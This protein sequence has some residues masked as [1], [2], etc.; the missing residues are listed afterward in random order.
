KAYP[1]EMSGGMCQRVMIAIALAARPALLIADEPT[2]GLD[3]T[4]QAVIMDIIAELAGEIGMATI[5]IT[6]DLALAGQRADRILVTPARRVVGDAA[7]PA[8]DR[9]SAAPL[10]G[11][12]HPPAAGSPPDPRR[13]PLDP[14]RAPRLAPRRSPAMLLFRT[15]PAQDRPLRAAAAAPAA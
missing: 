8:H 12:A 6:H 7:A 5:F 1:F 4:T 11:G 3:V 14:R 13:A 10:P 9:R 15:L 2:T